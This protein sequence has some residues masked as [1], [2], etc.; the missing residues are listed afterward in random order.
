LPEDVENR[1]DLAVVWNKRFPDHFATGHQLLEDLQGDADDIW[2]TSVKRSFDG[3]DQL[4]D[5][6][7]YFVPTLIQHIKHALD[8]QKPVWVLLLT[9]PI[10]EDWEV[11]MVVQLL[12]WDLPQDLVARSGMH[13]LNRKVASVVETTEFCCGYCAAAEGPCFWHMCLRLWLW[14]LQRRRCAAQAL[15]FLRKPIW[16]SR[17]LARLMHILQGKL[18]INCLLRNRIVLREI[19]KAGV[20]VT[21]RELTNL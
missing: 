16:R 17:G 21:W 6:W 19:S 18:S 2:V 11:V 13:D 3:D 5:N 14:P 10:K 7:E 20:T 4:W 15:P 9:N 12:N 8:R 1:E